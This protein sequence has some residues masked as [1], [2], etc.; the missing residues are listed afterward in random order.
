VG[1]TAE[2]ELDMNLTI[3]WGLD[4]PLT[5]RTKNI[6]ITKVLAEPIATMV[7]IVAEVGINKTPYADLNTTKMDVY[8]IQ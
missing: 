4:R 7:K 2:D 1:W 6:F 5:N 3:K 8:A